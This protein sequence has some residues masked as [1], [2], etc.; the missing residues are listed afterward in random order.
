MSETQKLKFNIVNQ[1]RSL[2]AHCSTQSEQA[3]NC[4]VQEI[5]LSVEHLQGVPLMV[6]SQFKGMLWNR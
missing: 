2:C 4:P 1:L 5:A 3:H 6:N